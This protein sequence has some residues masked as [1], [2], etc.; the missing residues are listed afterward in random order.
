RE[1]SKVAN[2]EA[3]RRRTADTAFIKACA[4]GV[5]CV[6][7]L[8]FVRF[9]LFIILSISHT[10]FSFTS[11]VRV[12]AIDCPS[13]VTKQLKEMLQHASASASRCDN[14]RD[15]GYGLKGRLP[16]LLISRE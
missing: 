6:S 9:S 11:F 5:L 16:A 10:S 1:V 7:L 14:P 4:R 3:P 2:C 8:I 15:D 13:P 12:F